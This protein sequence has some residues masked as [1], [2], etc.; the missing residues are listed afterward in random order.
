MS[1]LM[2]LHATGVDNQ[3][4]I[5]PKYKSPAQRKRRHEGIVGG[6]SAAGNLVQRLKRGGNSRIVVFLVFI[7]C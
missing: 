6:G 7:F 4:H 3:L 2:R 5:L 1:H